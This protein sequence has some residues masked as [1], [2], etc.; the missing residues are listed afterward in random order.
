MSSDDVR[1]LLP[2]YLLGTLDADEA[3]RVEAELASSAELQDEAEVWQNVLFS[4]PESFEPAPVDASEW[5]RLQ[6]AT[7]GVGRNVASRGRNDVQPSRSPRAVRQGNPPPA[8]LRPPW[9]GALLAAC[10]AL[11]LAL[12]GWGWLTA[13]ERTRLADE[14]RIIA[15]WMR[16]PDL[17]IQSLQG[18]GPGAVAAGAERPEISPG[19]VCVLPDGRAMVLQ[20]YA[21]PRGTRYVVI[22]MRDGQ[23]VELASSRQRLLLFDA[24]GLSNVDLTL[25][26]RRSET[27]ATA[28]F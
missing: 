23:R 2:Q 12:G 14:Q 26:G 15:Y 16:H 20:P 27:I 24:S 21:P 6:K 25:D 5:H 1:D 4:L 13:Q 28:T 9:S 18:V 11:V 17:A 7:F 3:E 10:V 8:W 19:V 22:G